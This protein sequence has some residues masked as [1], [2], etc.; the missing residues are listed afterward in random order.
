MFKHVTG[1]KLSQVISYLLQ[2][3]YSRSETSGFSDR[4][5]GPPLGSTHGLSKEVLDMIK[6]DVRTNIANR[7]AMMLDGLTTT[8][9][10]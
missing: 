8:S 2:Q 9:G 5:L 3:F 6:E 7:I 1:S 10:D 4:S